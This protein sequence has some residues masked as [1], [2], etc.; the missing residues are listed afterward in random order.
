M[1]KEYTYAL[2]S[3]GNMDMLTNGLDTMLSV[4]QNMICQKVKTFLAVC[5]QNNIIPFVNPFEMSMY[6]C[7]VI[8]TSDGSLNNRIM[9]VSFDVNENRWKLADDNRMETEPTDYRQ[10]LNALIQ[11]ITHNDCENECVQGAQDNSCIEHA[12]IG[13]NPMGYQQIAKVYKSLF[14]LMKQYIVEHIFEPTVVNKKYVN[15]IKNVILFANEHDDFI[16]NIYK[17]T[18]VKKLFAINERFNVLSDIVK[19]YENNCSIM[20]LIREYPRRLHND[21]LPARNIIKPDVYKEISEHITTDNAMYA[22]I[23]NKMDLR[24]INGTNDVSTYDKLKL[25]HNYTD[26]SIDIVI[27]NSFYKDIK[28]VLDIVKVKRFASNVLHPNGKMVL[29]YF[30]GN[31]K[32]QTKDV[33]GMYFRNETNNV[34]TKII[35]D[36]AKSIVGMQL[37][38]SLIKKYAIIYL[39]LNNVFGIDIED[40]VYASNWDAERV[41]NIVKQKGVCACIMNTECE[42]VNDIDG[43]EMVNVD[44]NGVRLMLLYNGIDKNDM[45]ALIKLLQNGSLF[46]YTAIPEIVRTNDVSA[47]V[48]RSV[49]Y[50]NASFGNHERTAINGSQ[51]QV[52]SQKEYVEYDIKW[53]VIPL[54]SN[55]MFAVLDDSFKVNSICTPLTEDKLVRHIASIPKYAK[56]NYVD[57]ILKSYTCVVYERVV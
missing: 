26:N 34:R 17:F 12:I 27:N 39:R 6:G 15:N 2:F 51:S 50:D 36:Y 13:V 18:D 29:N 28:S 24:V 40:L 47:R 21:G 1:T 33:S 11:T 52:F 43:V 9:P 32:G 23:N 37:D 14:K 25:N 22:I 30:N 46:E 53:T 56:I 4:K 57:Q 45:D 7:S 31:V 35:K 44:I 5:R 3:S 41:M 42:R 38:Q 48:N 16:T 8:S 19:E 10:A 20:S 54:V 55:E 49:S